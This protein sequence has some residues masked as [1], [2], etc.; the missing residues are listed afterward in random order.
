MAPYPA[1]STLPSW[2]V[3]D[4][5]QANRLPLSLPAQMSSNRFDMTAVHLTD[6]TYQGCRLSTEQGVSVGSFVTIHVSGFTEINGWIAWVKNGEVG[7]DFANPLPHA[8]TEHVL[9]LGLSNAPPSEGHHANFIQYLIC[10]YA[11]EP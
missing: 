1:P 11:G 7:L 3:S 6:L 5:R 9:R 10:G 8:V 2:L 4:E